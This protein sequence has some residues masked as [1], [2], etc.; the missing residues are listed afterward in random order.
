MQVDVTGMPRAGALALL[1]RGV[2]NLWMASNSLLCRE[3]FP[4]RQAFWWKMPDGRRLFVYIGDP[5]ANGF[6]WFHKDDWRVGPVPEVAATSFRPPRPGESYPSD[7]ASVRLAHARVVERVNSIEASGYNCPVL[8]L[9]DTNRWRMDNDPPVPHLAD[10]VATWNRLKLKPELVFTT[11][12]PAIEELKKHVGDRAPEA[13][14]EWTE[15]WANGIMS[16]PREVAASRIAKRKV[17]AAVSSV[18]GPVDEGTN[19]ASDDIY[20]NLCLFDEHT[21]GSAD[22]VGKPDAIATHGQYNEKARNAYQAMAMAELLLARRARTAIYDRE[23]G[24]YVA[25]T[26]NAP[27]TGWVEMC[28]SCLRGDVKSLVDVESGREIPLL[29]KSG[30]AQ[31]RAPSEPSEVTRENESQTCGDNIKNVLVRFW[32]DELPPQTI[33]RFMPSNQ[34]VAVDESTV[35]SQADVKTDELGWPHLRDLARHETAAF[36]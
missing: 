26:T 19:K 35:V 12:G 15:W 10:F 16:G 36:F 1:D 31:F 18:W 28:A 4:R 7:E 29:F 5:Y 24:F 21:W 23:E 30:Y 14:G 27:Y 34:D 22:S 33:K 6:D 20:R 17:A 8:L 2:E 13:S 9:Q 11:A 3:P 32:V 25:N